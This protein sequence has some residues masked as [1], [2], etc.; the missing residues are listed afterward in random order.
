MHAREFS[1]MDNP[2]T[3]VKAHTTY[4]Y[5]HTSITI[6]PKLS[7]KDKPGLT[8]TILHMD[9]AGDYYGPLDC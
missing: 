8:L 3:A 6:K 2:S 4:V 7:T 5:K 1:L 9:K